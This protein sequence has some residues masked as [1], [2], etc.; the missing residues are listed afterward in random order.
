MPVQINI[1][2]DLEPQE[3]KPELYQYID[4]SMK[5][6]AELQKIPAHILMFSRI[7][8]ILSVLKTQ[9]FSRVSDEE[10]LSV[11]ARVMNKNSL[12][13]SSYTGELQ[14]NL[15]LFHFV[16]DDFL[17]KYSRHIL[18]MN[19]VYGN[20]IKR[21]TGMLALLGHVEFKKLYDIPYSYISWE[22]I[23]S[24]RISTELRKKIFKKCNFLSHAIQYDYNLEE[25]P[26]ILKKN[27]LIELSLPAPEDIEC[28]SLI[29][30]LHIEYDFLKIIT[31][32]TYIS[33]DT[34]ID[35][36]YSGVASY[37]HVLRVWE[38]H[39]HYWGG[40]D[41]EIP[42]LSNAHPTMFHWRDFE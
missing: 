25:V 31:S 36:Y 16:D 5:S 28:N 3:L 37:E 29:N 18:T 12:A 21:M 32:N 23:N 24:T 8:Q 13:N 20:D 11:C 15:F 42:K 22:V 34:L 9:K 4:W 2:L 33:W 19:K 27:D 35:L 17:K 6:E 40:G 30:L 7:Q 1:K 10:V 39:I 38:I 26:I 14:L 41:V